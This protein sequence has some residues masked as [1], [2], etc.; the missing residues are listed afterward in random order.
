MLY[1]NKRLSFFFGFDES[2]SRCRLLEYD[3]VILE[4]LHAL[5]K[6]EGK[7]EIVAKFTVVFE[8]VCRYVHM[9]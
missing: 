8:A 4:T 9:E 7:K 6:K 2:N 5:G 1:T 3:I